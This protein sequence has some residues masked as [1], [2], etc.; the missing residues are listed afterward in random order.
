[1]EYIRFGS[2]NHDDTQ[3]ERRDRVIRPAGPWRTL[4]MGLAVATLASGCATLRSVCAPGT[5][6][7]SR[8]E[9]AWNKG[10]YD[11]GSV[12]ALVCESGPPSREPPSRSSIAE[13]PAAPAKAPVSEPAPK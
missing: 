9:V 4:A 6:S 3:G 2:F 5:W 7:A 11:T 10:P 13:Q 8:T 1:M 12:P